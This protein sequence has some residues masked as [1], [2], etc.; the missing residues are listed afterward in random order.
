VVLPLFPN[1]KAGVF[2]TDADAVA[3][4]CADGLPRVCVTRI[5]Q[6]SL[7]TLLGPAREALALLAKIPNA[8]TAVEEDTTY[9]QEHGAP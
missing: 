1:D 4:V 5:H 7:R 9:F 8:P 2:S 3:V 6:D